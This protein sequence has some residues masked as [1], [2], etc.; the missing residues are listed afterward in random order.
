MARPVKFTR[1]I[2]AEI[3]KNYLEAEDTGKEARAAFFKEHDITRQTLTMLV[4]KYN[5]V[6]TVRKTVE[7]V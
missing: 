4:K 1:E 2:V 5:L 3:Y 7:V 6:A